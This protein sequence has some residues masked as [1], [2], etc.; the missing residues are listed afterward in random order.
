MTRLLPYRATPA[1][2]RWDRVGDTWR[3][4]SDDG[5]RRVVVELVPLAA[6]PESWFAPYR[7]ADYADGFDV[8]RFDTDVQVRNARGE[9]TVLWTE[10]GS[11]AGNCHAAWVVE[12]VLREAAKQ[13]R[14]DKS[15]V[16]RMV[17]SFNEPYCSSCGG[18]D[19]HSPGCRW[20]P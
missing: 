1:V 8:G 5:Q 11:V 10:R 4:E 20:A 7:K 19:A 14:H 12:N 18:V 2:S 6:I 9:W 13:L 3:L 15:P 16:Q 17:A